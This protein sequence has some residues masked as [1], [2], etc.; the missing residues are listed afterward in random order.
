MVLIQNGVI[1][2]R[3]VRDE[4]SVLTSS[5]PGGS[6]E[7]RETSVVVRGLTYFVVMDIPMLRDEDDHSGV[8]VA[9]NSYQNNWPGSVIYRSSDGQ[10]YT[11]LIEL[12]NGVNAGW[13]LSNSLSSDVYRMWH[14]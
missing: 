8:Y 3:G 7:T 10:N 13:V 4:S 1:K 12:F 9:A 11:N 14:L 5:L 6:V 2:I